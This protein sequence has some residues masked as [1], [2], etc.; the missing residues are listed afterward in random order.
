MTAKPLRL[1]EPGWIILLAT[2]FLWT[3][4]L[5][6]IYATEVRHSEIP[7]NTVKQS[8]RLVISLI[9][10]GLIL[11]VGYQRIG[12][13]SFWIFAGAFVLLIPPVL[14]RVFHT[15]FGGVVP[16]INGSHRWIRL[17][18]FPLQPSECM[19]VA[20]VLAL[21]HYLRYRRNSRTLRGFLV[22]IVISAFPMGMILLEPDLGSVLMMIP[23][24]L[25]MLFAAGGKIS[26]FGLLA[27]VSLAV[28]PLAWWKMPGYQKSR[29]LGV[30]MQSDSLR[31]RMTDQPDEYRWL[32]A[33]PAE[34]AEEWE[35]RSGMQLVRSKT[36]IG[37]GGLLGAGW[38][39]GPYVEYNFLVHRHNDFVFSVICHQFGFLGALGVLAAY[40]LIIMSGVEI[41]ANTH[42]PF[43]RLLAFGVIAMI[44]CQ[45]LINISI[46][47]GLA[48]ITGTTL[49]FVSYGGSSLLTSFA[50]LALLVSVS[51]HRPFLLAGKPFTHARQLA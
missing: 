2:L 17:P 50:A 4:G 25:A 32:T 10:A 24:L 44:S 28:L 41:A 37:S 34:E 29:I 12:R 21:A 33:D 51:Q 13:Y 47:I 5:A 14:A 23:V 7:I 19:K 22:P 8:I 15:E 49:P 48:P 18:G 31:E 42:D 35:R 3:L 45:T 46:T 27:V 40:A 6:S 36:A 9:V 26:H 39:K 43:G 1:T 16:K 11:R 20:F 38:G 30:V